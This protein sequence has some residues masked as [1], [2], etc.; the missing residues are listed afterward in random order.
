MLE[1]LLTAAEVAEILHVK[2]NHVYQLRAQHKIPYIKVGGAVRF[3]EEKI[4][5]WLEQNSQK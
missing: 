2:P 1:K 4:K 5:T 3:S